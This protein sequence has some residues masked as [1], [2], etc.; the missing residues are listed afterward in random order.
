MYNPKLMELIPKDKIRNIAIIAHVDH[1]KTTLVDAIIKQSHLFRDNQEEM[2][3]DRILDSNDLEREKGITITAKNIS[4]HFGDYKINIIDTPGHADFGGE[5]ER[6]LNM[7]E[8]CVLVVDAQEGVMPQTRFVLRKAFEIGLKPIV[9]INKI[10][11]KL[12]NPKRTLS[13]IQDLFLDLAS[14]ESQ[15]EFTTLYGLARDGKVFRELPDA[16]GNN[17]SG[18][19][20]TVIPLLETIVEEI[21]SPAGDENGAFQMQVSSL[22]F[23]PHFGRYIIG[24]VLRGSISTAEDIVIAND[25]K[26][27]TNIKGKVKSLLI[28][29]G[30]EYKE[31]KKVGV[32][33]VVAIAG[34]DEAGI[35]D[36][37][38]DPKHIETVPVI[39]I[40]PP[41][42]KMRFEANTSP[43][44]GKEGKFPNWTQIQAR[45]DQEAQ[46]NV[47]LVIENN[48]DGSYSVS[49][50]GELHLAI[51]IESMRREGYEF[52]IRKPEVIT[53]VVDGV[54][55]EPVEEVYIEVPEEYY[56]AVSQEVNARK[57][58]LINIENENGQSKLIYRMFAR[59]LIGMRR[60]LLN[61][62]KG[63]VI[64]SN[65]FMEYAELKEKPDEQIAGRIVSQSLG[66]ALGYS[67]NTIQERGVL[68]IGPNV[69]VYEGMVIG[70]SKYENDML[71]NPTKAREKNNVRM[72][73]AEITLVNLKAPMEMTLENSIPMIRDDEIL[74][75]TPLNIRL[76]KKFLNKQQ[77]F[78]ANK[79]KRKA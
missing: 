36:T 41:S 39:Q 15:L 33:E 71:V 61:L 13:K 9:I 37:V 51:L 23:N 63:E 59:Y 68:L 17:Y 60:E 66:K 27:E 16:T 28:K 31:V 50:R 62:T 7:A 10:D 25:D 77:E 34:I 8:G 52:Q 67:L 11:K 20:G 22:D 14:D 1:G 26:P 5:V 79:R 32:G 29:E 72:S 30:L 78:E 76:R 35:G 4:V 74:E 70:I 6:T 55:M 73:R 18:V 57:G 47:G 38:C 46:T 69:D 58:E 19:D 75:I 24:K 49:G 2:D 64:M 56:S 40:S 65:N 45:L 3:Q 48:K 43:F 12:A 53:K 44:L 42:L 54:K 21:N